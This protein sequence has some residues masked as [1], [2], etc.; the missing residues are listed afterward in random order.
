MISKRRRA[1]N[2][3]SQAAFRGRQ[4]Q[5]TKELNEKLTQLEQ[6]H[7]DLSQSYESLHL[8]YSI[9]KQELETLQRTNSNHESM[10]L[11]RTTYHWAG[12]SQMETSD[13]FLIDSGEV[14]YDQP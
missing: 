9:V 3:A 8:E 5:K 12:E 13:L 10:S 1:Q 2:R 4:Q 11:W 7:Q 14:Y 6:K